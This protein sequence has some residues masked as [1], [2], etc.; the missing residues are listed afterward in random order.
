M[1]RYQAVY[2][3]PKVLVNIVIGQ[4]SYNDSTED[5]T[6]CSLTLPQNSKVGILNVSPIG[7]FP[8]IFSS[9]PRR[10]WNKR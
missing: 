9:I 2:L 5:L 1:L 7:T 8:E 6:S 4:G 3:F 10:K